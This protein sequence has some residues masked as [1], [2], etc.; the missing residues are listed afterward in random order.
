MLDSALFMRPPKNSDQNV[1]TAIKKS[2]SLDPSLPTHST[3]TSPPPKTVLISLTVYNRLSWGH[4][5]L[6]RSSQHALLASQTLGDLFEVIP[7]TSNDI[8]EERMVDGEV[9]GYETPTA[10]SA[11]R[12]SSGCVV[13]VEGKAYGDGMSDN[14]YAD[15]LIVHFEKFPSS[16]RDPIEKAQTSIYDTQLSSLPLRLN[17]PYY[18]LHQGNCEHFI[19]VDQIRLLHP[20]D[21]S[22]ASLPAPAPVPSASPSIAD[23]PETAPISTNPFPLTLQVTPPLPPLCRACTKV[24]AT[25]SIVGDIRLGE[26]PCVLCRVCWRVM[27]EGGEGVMVVPLPRYELGW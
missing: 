7:C 27:G 4:N 17:Q 5:L 15:K 3:I 8:P 16:K 23:T 9:V 24:P 14:D 18:L 20:S 11:G 19:V 1:L 26:S 6:S 2:A 13:C 21:P 22:I 10:E 12:G 25:Y